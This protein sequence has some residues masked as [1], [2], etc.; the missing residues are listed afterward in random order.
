MQV[1]PDCT[2]VKSRMRT[3]SS[4]LPAS[5][6]GFGWDAEVPLRVTVFAAGRFG[7]SFTTFLADFFAAG[8]AFAF[9]AFLRVAMVDYSVI[10]CGPRF[11]G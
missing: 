7:L 9:A 1:G 11:A 2:W 10:S 6:H 3:P 8:L 5:P 4:A